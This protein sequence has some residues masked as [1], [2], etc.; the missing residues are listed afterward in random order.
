MRKKRS[1]TRPRRTHRFIKE[2]EGA[3]QSLREAVSRH[4]RETMLPFPHI[5][6]LRHL[7]V[8]LARGSDPAP[9]QAP[10]GPV[11][12]RGTV[13]IHGTNAAVLQTGPGSELRCQS[14][15][16]LID[17]RADNHGFAAFVG[18]RRASFEKLFS[19]VRAS[20]D[21]E[22]ADAPCHLFG[23]FAGQGVQKGVAVSSVPKFFAIFAV[24]VDGRFL[25]LALFPDLRDDSSR[26]FNVLD[27]GTWALE[28][29]FDA[30]L[31]VSEAIEALTAAV[32]QSCPAGKQLGVV[33]PGEGLVWQPVNAV[34]ET[35]LWFKSK[36]EAFQVVVADRLAASQA[37]ASG[38]K[39][40]ARLFAEATLTP[41]RV[42]QGGE[43]GRE[44]GVGA[45]NA[46]V[47]WCVAD[48]L[49][50]EGVLLQPL[51]TAVEERGLRSALQR[52][53]QEL[54]AG[55]VG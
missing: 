54:L 5:G 25:D 14:R 42:R 32:A 22:Q 52:R 24:C 37:E 28:V 15:T 4:T 29:P 51:P 38:S 27:F 49:R 34:E 12:Y 10:P 50:E 1:K 31:S 18:L 55:V 36:G 26:I 43:A 33:G 45:L 47:A 41:E 44:T 9:E 17:E 48:A 30:P 6:Q 19:K 53:A 46:A 2:S 8:H 23:E 20:L 13:K 7:A 16:R 3:R 39:E 40:C 21:A 35:S 11:M